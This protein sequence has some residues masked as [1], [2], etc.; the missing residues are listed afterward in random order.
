M[1]VTKMRTKIMVIVCFRLIKNKFELARI[2]HYQ[3]DVDLLTSQ[4]N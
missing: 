4:K 3:I 2:N 1:V